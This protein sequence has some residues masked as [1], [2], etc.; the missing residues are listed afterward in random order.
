MN[1]SNTEK[2]FSIIIDTMRKKATKP[3][4]WQE[5]KKLKHL[6]E[7]IKTEQKI[8]LENKIKEHFRLYGWEKMHYL[9]E[10]IIGKEALDKLAKDL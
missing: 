3:G 2:D 10:D 5:V 4:W 6:M 8:E 1:K 9:L 7:S